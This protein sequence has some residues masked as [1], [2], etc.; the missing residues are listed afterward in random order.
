MPRTRFALEV[1][2]DAAGDERDR[3]GQR[4]DAVLE[5]GF[6]LE[7]E[8]LPGVLEDVPVSCAAIPNTSPVARRRPSRGLAM[9][10]PV[11]QVRLQVH[12]TYSWAG[13]VD[14]FARAGSR[15]DVHVAHDPA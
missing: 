7:R 5:R 2:L 13:P 10:C 4:R 8:R 3:N 15:I 6:G 14:V 11:A 12:R 1:T 9:T